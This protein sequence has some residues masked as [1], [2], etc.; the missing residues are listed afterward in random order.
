MG[1]ALLGALAGGVGPA[2]PALAC[3]SRSRLSTS[4]P[5]L[6][7]R[8]WTLALALSAARLLGRSLPSARFVHFAA[9][10]LNFAG[11]ARAVGGRVGAGFVVGS[12]LAGVPFAV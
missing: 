10:D 5:S 4:D 2:G 7:Y 8:S 12:S 6:S 9:F 3:S 11:P 1:S